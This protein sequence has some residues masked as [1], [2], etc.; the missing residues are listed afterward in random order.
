M[1]SASRAENDP[2]LDALATVAPEILKDVIS[3]DATGAGGDP[4][5]DIPGEVTDPIS[6]S[7]S[8]GRHVDLRLP[9]TGEVGTREEIADGIVSFDNGDGSYSVPIVK[10]GGSVQVATVITSST[11]PTSYEYA[12]TVPEGASVAIEEGGMVIVRN[13]QGGY[14]AGILPAWAKDADGFA[15][16]THFEVVESTVTQVIEHNA[17]T[18]YPVVADPWIGIDL[19]QATYYNRKGLYRSKNT[20][21]GL[22]SP[23]AQAGYYNPLSTLTW[24]EIMRTA[25]W[26][27][28]ATKRPIGIT[29]GTLYPSIRQQYDCHV[30]YGRAVWLSGLHWDL[31]HAR[32]NF[33]GWPSTALDHQCNW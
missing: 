12:L 6:I 22:M 33:P 28:L 31:E 30:V 20:T 26:S 17:E 25:G 1:A 4:D 18:R 27:E 10:E 29:A 8:D 21:S 32:A 23:F 19:F 24:G 16:P 5:V 11:A 9:N 3:E 15:I 13:A 2:L 14:V 7:S